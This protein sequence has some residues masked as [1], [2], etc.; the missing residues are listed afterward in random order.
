[1]ALFCSFLDQNQL[2]N[3]E[4]LFLRNTL[5]N[6]LIN[7][8]ISLRHLPYIRYSLYNLPIIINLIIKNTYIHTL[9]VHHVVHVTWTVKDLHSKI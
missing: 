4:N 9:G 7:L 3:K 5:S 2:K 1:M 6:T 8:R